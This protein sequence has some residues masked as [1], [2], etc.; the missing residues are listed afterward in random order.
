[1]FDQS[2]NYSPGEVALITGLRSRG[3]E[4]SEI[5]LKVIAAGFR[6]RRTDSFRRAFYRRRDGY[7][8][9]PQMDRH[10]ADVVDNSEV[11]LELRRLMRADANFCKALERERPRTGVNMAAGTDR[12][13]TMVVP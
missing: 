2:K 10:H 7:V 9:L 13:Q 6:D 4:W 1:M 11:R 12:P 3:V 8:R 5:R